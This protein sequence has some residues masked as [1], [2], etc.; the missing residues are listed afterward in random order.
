MPCKVM[1]HRNKPD[2]LVIAAGI[3]KAA[4]LEFPSFLLG[5][6]VDCFTQDLGY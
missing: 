4:S 3:D 5:L 1:T 2:F 6:I